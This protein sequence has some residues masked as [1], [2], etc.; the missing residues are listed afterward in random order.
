M[1]KKEF[2]PLTNL[3]HQISALEVAIYNLRQTNTPHL[4]AHTKKM[5]TSITQGLINTKNEI[6]KS[7]N[8]LAD[9]RQTY[10]QKMLQDTKT[11]TDNNTVEN[12][13]ELDIAKANLVILDEHETLVVSCPNHHD[14]IILAIKNAKLIVRNFCNEH[15][16]EETL[17]KHTEGLPCIHRNVE[18]IEQIYISASEGI[19]KP[20]LFKIEETERGLV[21]KSVDKKQK[22]LLNR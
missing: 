21:I 17:K 4:N 20:L 6:R 7:V 19:D 14:T 15:A 8:Q 18:F 9:E 3:E 22:N 2:T 1:D 11:A 10:I 13:T 5:L 16:N 12:N